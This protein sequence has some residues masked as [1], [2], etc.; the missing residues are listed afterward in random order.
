MVV[1]SFPDPA[2]TG[3]G[4]P[5]TGIIRIPGGAVKPAPRRKTE[6]ASETHIEA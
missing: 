5:V 2:Q 6:K 1:R 4:L 3:A